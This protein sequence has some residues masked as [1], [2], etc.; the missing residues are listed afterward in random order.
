[1]MLLKCW[2]L[3][4][5]MWFT[6]RKGWLVEWS[7]L[8]IA[9]LWRSAWFT[10]RSGRKWFASMLRR[11]RSSLSSHKR[12]IFSSHYFCSSDFNLI[13]G[14]TCTSRFIQDYTFLLLFFYT[15]FFLF[16]LFGF[17]HFFETKS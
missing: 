12:I 17:F 4:L 14:K 7:M 16:L 8:L 10:G 15:F 2:F 11:G 13:E 6:L 3:L 5:E 9:S 1:M